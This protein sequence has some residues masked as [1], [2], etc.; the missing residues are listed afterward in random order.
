MQ[1]LVERQAINNGQTM[2][3]SAMAYRRHRGMCVG[4]AYKGGFRSVMWNECASLKVALKFEVTLYVEVTHLISINVKTCLTAMLVT[5]RQLISRYELLE[6][7]KLYS[8]V[9]TGSPRYVKCACIYIYIMA[10]DKKLCL[11]DMCNL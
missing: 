1:T 6:E 9:E 3:Q 7:I 5:C 11:V 10:E 8:Y 2:S 4:A